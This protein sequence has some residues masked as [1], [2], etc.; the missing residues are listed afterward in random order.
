MTTQPLDVTIYKGS[1]K[2]DEYQVNAD[3]GNPAELT[4][5]LEQWLAANGWG[6]ILWGQFELKARPAGRSGVLAT[7]RMPGS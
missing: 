3:P 6:R 5:I 7:V 1:R 4:G 2:F